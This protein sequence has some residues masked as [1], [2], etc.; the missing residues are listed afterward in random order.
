MI[1]LSRARQLRYLPRMKLTTLALL[2][3]LGACAGS[4]PATK[5]DP[6]ANTAAQGTLL[7]VADLKFYAGPQLV[8]HVFADGVFEEVD[9]RGRLARVATI[10]SDGKLVGK[11]GTG[12]QL[13]ADGT[14]VALRPTKD[15][16]GVKL[17]GDTLIVQGEDGPHRMT[18]DDK[19]TV[20]LDGKPAERALRV[21]GVTDRNTRRTALLVFGLLVLPPVDA[22]AQHTGAFFVKL[23]DAMDASGADCDKLALSVQALA[24]DARALRAEL[25]AAHRKLDDMKEPPPGV[26]ARFAALKDPAA[27][28]KCESNPRVK[29]AL[30]AT[31]LV[32]APIEENSAFVNAFADAFGKAMAPH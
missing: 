12:A 19:G 26:E 25:V 21:E 27:I 4:Q 3:L 9:G 22:I 6:A 16:P 8:A 14:L 13:Q 5:H 18:L 17:E 23:A 29:Q 10:T 28:E 15:D 32:I 2:S 31:L 1:S 24:P 11:D 30:D 20:L 7:G